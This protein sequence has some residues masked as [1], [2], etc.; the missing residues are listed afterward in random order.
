[1]A[2]EGE[3]QDFLSKLRASLI[4]PN[5]GLQAAGDFAV[6]YGNSASQRM[7]PV[8]KAGG[9]LFSQLPNQ[10]PAYGSAA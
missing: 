2:Q 6:G 5:A 1:V 9:G 7:L 4:S 10:T 8:K 3:G